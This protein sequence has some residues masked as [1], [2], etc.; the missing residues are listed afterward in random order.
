MEIDV[1]TLS[2]IQKALEN[3]AEEM[4]IILHRASFSPNCKERLDFSCAIFDRNAELLAQAEHI[5]VHLGA[6]FSS[7]TAILQEFP[8]DAINPGDIIILNSPFTGGTHLPDVTF[9]MPVYFDN[10][11]S[12]FVNNRAHH[13]DIGGSTPGSMPG[14]SSELFEEGLIIPPVKLYNRGKEVK[15]I[16]ELILS[17][18]RIRE[19]RL[20]DFRAQRASLLRGEERLVELTN[21]YGQDFVFDACKHLMDISEKAFK[22]Q[23]TSFPNGKF[24]YEDY[25]DSNGVTDDLVKIEVTITKT[26]EKINVSF[27]GTDSQQ[28]GNVNAPRS[29][30]FSCVYYVFRALTDPTIMTNAGLFRNIEIEIP[31]GSLLDPRSPAAVSSGNVETSQRIVDVLLGALAQAL[32]E[33]PAASQGTMNNVT[34]GGIDQNGN[35]FT[36][37]ETIGGGVGSSMNYRGISGVH[38]HMTNTLNT[39]IEA[40]EL[41][42]PLRVNRYEFRIPSGGKGKI[43]GGHGLIREIEC[44]TDAVVS[45]QTERRKLSPYGLHGG[46]DGAK[47]LNIKRKTNNDEI[48]LAG[49]AIVNFKAGEILVINTPGGGG[50]GRQ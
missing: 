48:E 47:G 22:R 7:I 30:V 32:E 23:I 14:I 12:F 44:L 2:T 45:L 16:M 42:Y 26:D 38:S 9:L 46:G 35:P 17:N 8:V 33:I 19:E 4:G 29:V 50:Y 24:Q 1:I 5:P 6:M 41:A 13:A 18:V 15:D 37:Y 40:L 21:K 27:V 20:G 10:S 3:I 49:R 34:I 31:E 39:P 28:T 25:L 11:L 43:E 36:Y